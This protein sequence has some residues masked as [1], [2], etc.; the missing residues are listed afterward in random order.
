MSIEWVQ[1]LAEREVKKVQLLRASVHERYPRHVHLETLAVCNAA[2]GFCPYP[3]LERQGTRMPEALIDKIIG[4]LE[5]IPQK[6]PFM[7]AP[8]KVNEPFLDVRLPDILHR[9]NE[10][11]PSAA[12]CLFSNGSAFTERS[13]SK[14]AKIENIEYLVI[15]LNEYEPEPYEALMQMPLARTLDRL[16]LLHKRAVAGDL[17]FPVTINRVMDGSEADMGFL[18]WGKERF[19]AFRTTVSLRKDW[20]GQVDEQATFHSAPDLPCQRWFD[21]SIMATGKVTICCMDGIGEW[22]IGDASESNLLD[23]YNLPKQRAI[24]LEAKSRLS[25]EACRTCT[26]L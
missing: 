1:E 26:H 21:L 14:L 23:L 19:P 4:D 7:L 24:R 17:F 15:S 22:T 3:T 12:I 2:C 11:L 9:I 5:A 20:N 16:E 18:A 6:V 8:Y 25:V 13:L 10:R